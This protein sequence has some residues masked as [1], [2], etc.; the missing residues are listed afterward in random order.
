MIVKAHIKV[1]CRKPNLAVIRE[2]VQSWL[3]ERQ[4]TGT[5]A[6]QIVLAVDEASANCMI[7]QH[8]CDARSRI[9]VAISRHQN[10]VEVEI[11]DTGRA[12]RIDQYKP[13]GISELI[14]KRNKG[15]MGIQLIHSI[16]DEIEIEENSK[17][18]VYRFAKKLHEGSAQR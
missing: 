17:F 8:Q 10:K 14:Q 9:E 16:M 18:F 4:I 15:G 5:V 2:F 1:R 11:K 3:K 13:Q 12:F 6:N 7:H